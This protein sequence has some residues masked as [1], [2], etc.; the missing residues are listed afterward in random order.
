MSGH[1]KVRLKTLHRSLGAKDHQE[2]EKR[3]S[4]ELFKLEQHFEWV[5]AYGPG[6]R[7]VEPPEEV[8][9]WIAGT[10]TTFTDV[11]GFPTSIPSDAL[12]V[13]L[14]IHV[15]FSASPAASAYIEARADGSS[16][17]GDKLKKAH[18][19]DPGGAGDFLL[20]ISVPYPLEARVTADISTNLTTFKAYVVEY[21]K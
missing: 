7:Q 21:Y 11:T 8:T 4:E 20:H 14:M 9:G 13:K 19:Q 2:L 3:V 10:N 16:E 5:A 17:T 6:K 18:I 1:D 15:V 12:G